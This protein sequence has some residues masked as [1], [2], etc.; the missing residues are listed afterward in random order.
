M[1]LRRNKRGQVTIFVILAIVIVALVAGYFLIVDSSRK[2][3]VPSVF[4]PTYNEFSSCLENVVSEGDL[5]LKS[6]GG[7]ID[8]PIVEKASIRYPFTN[9]LDYAGIE[10][11]YWVYYSAS[12]LPKSK[13]PSKESMEKEMELYLNKKWTFCE[14]QLYDSDFDISI[15]EPESIDV[16]IIDNKIRVNIDS[17]MT[18]SNG[19]DSSSVKEHYIEVDSRLGK[20]FDSAKTVFEEEKNE[21]LIGNY[22]MDVLRL[23]APVDGVELSCSP[24]TWNANEVFYELMN[25]F[26]QNFLMLNNYGDGKDYYNLGSDVSENIEIV[27]SQNWPGFFE[28][29]P[30]QEALMISRPVGNQEGLGVLGFCYVPYH[31]VYNIR[32]PILIQISEGE[33]TFQFPYVLSIE[34]N[35]LRKVTV[36][37]NFYEYEDVCSMQGESIGISVYDLN[38]NLLDD[39]NIY[40]DC[41]GQ[42]CYVGKT[43][44]GKYKGNLP[45][46]V[47]GLL[48]VEK[49]GY[50]DSSLRY[51]SNT[52]GSANFVLNKFYSQEVDL[53][54]EGRSYSQEAVIIFNSEDYSATLKYPFNNRILIPEGDYEISVYIYDNSSF[55]IP[56]VTTQCFDIPRTGFGGLLGLTSEECINIEVSDDFSSNVLV[57]GGKIE[58]FFSE[59]A[60]RSSDLISLEIEGLFKTESFEDLQKNYLLVEENKIEVS[61]K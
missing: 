19:I 59:E 6:H 1:K 56:S 8:V 22:S 48:R 33:E 27:Y 45:G 21:S 58:Y 11:P 41:L 5:I 42:S 55:E 15:E 44:N 30:S 38:L 9:K 28:V 4:E 36:D 32:I 25:G 18:I 52:P 54:V 61:L 53:L 23:Y 47:N 17:E 13:I 12:G 34:K 31:F 3:K 26:E 40:Y 2:E 39:V 43:E 29:D 14:K 49:D 24:L 37:E 60:L 7:V 35:S 50:K 46:C 10:I 51:S 16:E 20:L 57:G